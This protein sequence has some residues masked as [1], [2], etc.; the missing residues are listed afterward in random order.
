MGGSSGIS[1]ILVLLYEGILTKI[2][3]GTLGKMAL[4]LRVEPVRGGQI[5]WGQS[6][7]RILVWILP[8]YVTCGLWGIIDNLW[9][10]W[11]G[12]KQTLHDK[13]VKTLVVSAR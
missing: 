13:V 1:L 3:G 11:D 4:G 8:N 9:C 5:S 10:T 6:I 2:K 12:R 7:V